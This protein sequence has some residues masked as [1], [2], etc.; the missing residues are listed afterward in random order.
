M[1]ERN[2]AQ[3]GRYVY[4]IHEELA[5]QLGNKYFTRHSGIIALG[6]LVHILLRAGAGRH[7]ARPRCLLARFSPRFGCSSWG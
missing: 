6:V 4:H 5:K 1:D 2:A 7:G 3:N